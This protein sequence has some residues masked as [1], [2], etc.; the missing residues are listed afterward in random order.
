MPDIE[1]HEPL[2]EKTMNGVASSV[3][4]IGGR[5]NGDGG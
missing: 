2:I 4:R 5:F 1:C 3:A